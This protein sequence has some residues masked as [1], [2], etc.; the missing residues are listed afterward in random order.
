MTKLVT[1]V[2]WARLLPIWGVIFCLAYIFNHYMSFGYALV[3]IIAIGLVLPT[4]FPYT[5]K[6]QVKDDD[7]KR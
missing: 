4:I 1:K 6:V 2:N 5:Y 3:A 7:V